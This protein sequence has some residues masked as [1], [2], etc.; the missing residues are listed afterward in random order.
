MEY[1]SN[2]L[3]VLL[4]ESAD[5]CAEKFLLALMGVLSPR[6]TNSKGRR[7]PKEDDLHIL[8]VEYLSNHLL[9]HTQISNLSLYVQTIFCKSFK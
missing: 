9:D 2:D 5:M 6:R 7:P 3:W 4:K 1:Y 8:K